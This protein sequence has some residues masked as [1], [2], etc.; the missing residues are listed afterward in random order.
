MNLQENIRKVLK[1]VRVPRNERVELY[2]D[3]NIIV[4]VPLT[5]R[6]LQ[7]YAHRCLWCI[8]DDKGEWED[9][10]KGLH[11]IIIQRNPKKPKIGITGQPVPSEI[12][13]LAKWDNNDASFEDVCQML[14]YEFRNDR[15]MADYYGTIS[16]DINNF[17]T[18]I[19]YYSPENGIYDQEDNFLVGF[20]YEISDIPNVTDEVIRIMDDY[21]QEEK[22]IPLQENIRKVLRE[23]LKTKFFLR[24]VTPEEVARYFSS[25]DGQVFF[26]TET[27]EEFKYQLVL[28]S[29]EEVM[30]Q[31]YKMGWEDLPEQEEIDYVN[32]VAEMYD[33]KIRRLYNK[34]DWFT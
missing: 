27:Y 29:L 14:E 6:A 11:A 16:N 23:E 33:D 10:H 30:W 22:E 28:K 2:R 25:F 32:Q 8:N 24:R 31:E 13:L 34:T 3:N 7:K 5:H 21:L 18:N 19:V 26:E 9:Y 4:V 1:E 17:G 12:F 20:N 15:T